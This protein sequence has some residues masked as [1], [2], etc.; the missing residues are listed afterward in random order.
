V[1]ENSS[2]SHRTRQG[3]KVYAAFCCH[4]PCVRV[5]GRA[6]GAW[7]ARDMVGENSVSGMGGWVG[8]LGGG[9]VCE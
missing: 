7:V 6:G 9:Q 1:P 8:L 5:Q 2:A 4:R 3:W